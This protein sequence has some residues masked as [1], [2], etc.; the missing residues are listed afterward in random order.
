VTPVGRLFSGLRGLLIGPRLETAALPR[1]RLSRLR[2][3]PI[4]AADNLSNAAYATDE[5]LIILIVAGA[6][7]LVWSVPI[8]LAL[9]A[10]VV[11]VVT[12]YRQT[13]LAFCPA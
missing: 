10:L 4:Y 12:S 9:I 3:L 11:V 1:E 13:I 8:T 7:A 5:I 6:G 2:A